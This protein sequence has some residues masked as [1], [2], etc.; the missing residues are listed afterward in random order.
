MIG[1]LYP[2]ICN[3]QGDQG[4]FDWLRANDIAACSIGDKARVDL[5]AVFVGDV[6]ERGAEMLRT[7]LENHW[8]LSK[9]S[10][11]LTVVAIGRAGLE[12]AKALGIRAPIDSYSSEF[13]E[14]EFLGKKLYG[15]INGVIDKDRLVTE[16][17]IGQ[18]RFILSALLG[19]ATVVNPWFENYCFGI[20]T[21]ARDD[22][23]EHYK[24]LVVD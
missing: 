18:G 20:Q 4:Y 13:V 19:P 5:Q 15:Y 8:L 6:S 23:T 9:I 1:F 7:R 3:Q 22:L 17:Q 2:E 24:N 12:V 21:S 10:E 16:T 14:T 11:G